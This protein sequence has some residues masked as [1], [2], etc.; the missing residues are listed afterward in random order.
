MI[1]NNMFK[2]GDK[3]RMRRTV[4][5]DYIT[6]EKGCAGEVT[7]GETN[8]GFC[9]VKMTNAENGKMTE[10][11]I[12]ANNLELIDNKTAFLSDLA[13]VL[14]KHNAVINVGWNDGWQA[15][16]AKYPLIDMDILFNDSVEGICLEDVLGKS[17]TADNIMDYEKE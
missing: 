16:D 6:F 13:A 11:F 14:R 17:L 8:R 2:K 7:S 10:H 5:F 3:V 12:C 1:P 15:D 9:C 4:C